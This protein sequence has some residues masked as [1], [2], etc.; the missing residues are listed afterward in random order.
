[1]SNQEVVFAVSSETMGC[2]DMTALF[3]AGR[4]K[5]QGF[6]F[7]RARTSPVIQKTSNLVSGVEAAL[8]DICEHIE[9]NLMIYV[10]SKQLQVYA[11]ANDRGQ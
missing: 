1:M 11:E 8:P 2:R 7:F 3:A 6:Y 5:R 10:R 9:V 4:R